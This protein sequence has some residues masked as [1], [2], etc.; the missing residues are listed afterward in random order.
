MAS[1]VKH[2]ET[3]SWF[4]GY[5]GDL[6]ICSAKRKP[7]RAE[8]GPD[9][10]VAIKLPYGCALCVVTVKDCL[11]SDLFNGRAA[12]P[13]SEAER[14]LGDYTIGRWIWITENCRRLREPIPMRGHQGLW[15]VT[16]AE[17]QT[18]R[19]QIDLA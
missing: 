14:D 17:E 10:E 15:T 11:P 3:R 9:Y 4:L 13:L 12:L 5:R 8:A 19:A 1:G 2:N 6:L 7:S 18:I 16:A